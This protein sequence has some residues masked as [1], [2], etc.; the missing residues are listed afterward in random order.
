MRKLLYLLFTI[1]FLNSCTEDTVVEQTDVFVQVRGKT[2]DAGEYKSIYSLDQPI[3]SIY[4]YEGT[5]TIDQNIKEIPLNPKY[6]SLLK[7]VFNEKITKGKYTLIAE[8]SIN[9]NNTRVKTIAYY[10]LDYGKESP[11]SFEIDFHK[12]GVSTK[13]E[14]TYLTK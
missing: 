2:T 13:N 14:I 1:T 3:C 4:I 11:K 8:A 10:Y 5:L 7:D 6:K 9:K 12:K